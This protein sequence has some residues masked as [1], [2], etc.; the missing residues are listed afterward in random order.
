MEQETEADKRAMDVALARYAVIAPLIR[1]PLNREEYRA[2]LRR[3][4]R[5]RDLLEGEVAVTVS[6][7]TLARWLEWYRKGHITE[8]G[9]VLC[10]PGF[11]ALKP[12]PR[13]DCGQTRAIDSALIDRAVELR[14]QEPARTTA[15]LIRL[16]QAELEARGEIAPDIDEG[17]LGRHLRKRGAR[18]QDLATEGRIHPRYEHDHRNAV[19]QGDWSQG[20]TLPDPVDPKKTRTCHLH[21]FI[22]DHT[23]YVIHAEFY[24]RQNLPCLEDCFRK[25]ILKGGIPERAYWD[26]GAVYH[27][28]QIQLLAARL[29]TH[30]IFATPYAP[31]G[32]GKIERWF[33]TVKQSLYPEARRAGLQTL[34]QLN[35]FLW[36]WLDEYHDRV[37]SETEATP[38]QR[39]DAQ[40]A[41][42]RVPEPS[43]LVDLFLWEATRRVDKAGCIQLS[44]NVYAVAEHL[45]RREVTVRFDPF[46]LSRIRIFHN[47]A[48]I[49]TVEPLT[50]ASRTFHRAKAHRANDKNAPLESA[51]IYRNRLSR[52]FQ[53]SVDATT[54]HASMTTNGSCLTRSTLGLLL[55]E[56]LGGRALTVLEANLLADFFHRCAP[57]VADSARA[58]LLAAVEEK[59]TQRHVR[60]YLDAIREARLRKGERS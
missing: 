49:E 36:G 7:R 43:E 13:S 19:W 32:K 18:R 3:I 55:T 9:V 40:A 57:I 27:A 35:Q 22:D 42:I 53:Q 15:T 46:D 37:H 28:R 21:A 24:F 38:R 30:V 34:D 2:E 39:W 11:D 25:A 52:A 26:N 45:V 8:A 60:F 10:K 44:G 1:R 20:I 54:Q 31:E 50:M 12:R 59:G 56:C 29:G 17:T 16:I 48:L 14:A 58:A 51:Q 4:C 5:G 23:R 6:P 47:Q 41:G 33:Q